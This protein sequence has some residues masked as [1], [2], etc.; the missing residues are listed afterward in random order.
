MAYFP[1]YIN[2][3]DTKVVV[4]GA[5]KVASRKIKDVLEYG[6]K[7]VVIAPMIDEEIEKMSVCNDVKIIKAEFTETLLDE[8]LREGDISFVVA[9]TN[10]R[11]VNIIISSY[12]K[13]RRIPIN[14][15]DD[16]EL[17]SFI[18]SSIYK[19]GDIICGISSGGKG[20]VITQYIR[21]ILKD[22][23]PDNIGEIADIMGKE[24]EKL[25]KSEP[26]Q[27]KRAVILREL[28]KELVDAS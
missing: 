22:N 6:A 27:A 14:V 9:A 3:D 20:P 8:E 15:V 5:G 23:L 17:C 12:C 16:T 11:D 13:S 28:L 4:I 21:D 19:N 18:F 7:V 25:K 2:L 1:L 24:R 26:N 10:N